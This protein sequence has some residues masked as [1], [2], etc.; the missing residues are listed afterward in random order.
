MTG[1]AARY[2]YLARHG[3]ASPDESRLTDNGHRQAVLLG[4]RLQRSPLSAVHHG[5][6]PR[7]EKTSRPTSPS[8]G[9]DPP[10]ALS[11]AN[12][13]TSRVVKR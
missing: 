4:E 3:E 5:P 12:L 13:G 6:L 10:V 11:P 2:L 9:S 7:A 1:T 8:E